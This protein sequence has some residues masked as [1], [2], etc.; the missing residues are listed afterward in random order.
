[1]KPE[2]QTQI[3]VQQLIGRLVIENT[4]LTNQLEALK[5]ELEELKNN[6]ETTHPER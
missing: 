4:A 3:S 6:K 2:E 1:M 5:K